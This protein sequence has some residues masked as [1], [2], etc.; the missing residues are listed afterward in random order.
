MKINAYIMLHILHRYDDIVQNH[1]ALDIP[2]RK[3]NTGQKAL[4][5][6]G[7]KT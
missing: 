7:P 6:L 1:V 5:F 2:L 4:S 3:A